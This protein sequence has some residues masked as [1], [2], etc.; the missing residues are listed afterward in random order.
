[1]AAKKYTQ[2][3]EF[4]VKKKEQVTHPEAN[5]LGHLFARRQALRQTAQLLLQAHQLAPQVALLLQ[6]AVDFSVDL[7]GQV[8][9]LLV[10][11]LQHHR[12]LLQLLFLLSDFSGEHGQ[13]V[14]GAVEDVQLLEDVVYLP[15]C[16][17][18]KLPQALS[19]LEEAACQATHIVQ[20][21]KA[22]MGFNLS[23]GLNGGLLLFAKHGMQTGSEQKQ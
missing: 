7:D 2:E 14:E 5:D 17:L 18:H 21:S 9:D 4:Y 8:L 1:M 19:Q 15:L 6:H 22:G 3:R 20:G 16:L 12:G 13:L 23:P 10:V 11:G